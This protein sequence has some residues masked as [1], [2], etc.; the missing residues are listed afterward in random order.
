MAAP[1][2]TFSVLLLTAAPPTQP[3]EAG[4]AFVKIDGRE[5]LVRSVELF[6]NRPN[7]KQIQVVF[8][9]DDAE[10]AKRKH[11]PHLSFSGVKALTG[12]PLW[13]DQIAAASGKIAPEATHVLVHDAARPAVPFSDIDALLD[14]AK[15]MKT[16]ALLLAA[17]VRNALVEI[18]AHGTPKSYRPAGDYMNLL[19][20]LLFTRARFDQMAREKSEVPPSE[21]SL[22]KGSPLNVRV[23]GPGDAALAKTMLSMLPKPKKNPL[24]NP[25]E[26]AQW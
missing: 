3:A 26:E 6:L 21:T 18:D 16:P 4:G 12:G 25:F 11:G 24:T 9:P 8:Q 20:P 10:E 19:T 14:C 13:I 22:L 5:S 2:P 1:D 7:I 23:S 15:S 17:P